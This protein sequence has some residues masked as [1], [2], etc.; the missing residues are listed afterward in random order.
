[1]DGQIGLAQVTKCRVD[2][3]KHKQHLRQCLPFLAANCANLRMLNLSNCRWVPLLS[4]S[5]LWTQARRKG[6]LA[7]LLYP[8]GGLVVQDRRLDAAPLAQRPHT[9]R[10]LLDTD[11]GYTTRIRTTP[12]VAL[13]IEQMPRT[14]RVAPVV[15][16]AQSVC[17]SFLASSDA[18]IEYLPLSL[19]YLYLSD[20]SITNAVRVRVMHSACVSILTYSTGS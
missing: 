10:S 12:L 20:N 19:R 11:Y 1:V 16:S 14:T 4:F 15:H 18:C 13:T 2:A 6:A 17:F 5:P 9:P 3:R 8:L 7:H